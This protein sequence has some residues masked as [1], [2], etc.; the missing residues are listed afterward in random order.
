MI[1]SN[2][3]APNIAITPSGPTTICPP[4]TV[5]L[6]ASGGDS[7]VWSDAGSGSGSSNVASAAGN[8]CVEATDNTNGC[9]ASTCVTFDRT[10]YT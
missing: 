9:T 10:L 6:N 4:Q 5:T 3:T 2:T 7:Y 1:S 8:Y